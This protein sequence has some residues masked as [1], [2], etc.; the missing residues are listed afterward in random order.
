MKNKEME[1]GGDSETDL[2]RGKEQAKRETTQDSKWIFVACNKVCLFA[3]RF[4]C[5]WPLCTAMMGRWG[6]VKEPSLGES[7]WG[8]STSVFFTGGDRPKT[9]HIQPWL[10]T[11]SVWTCCDSI[12]FLSKLCSFVL[13][14]NNLSRMSKSGGTAL[15]RVHLLLLSISGDWLLTQSWHMFSAH[16]VNPLLS[17]HL[18]WPSSPYRTEAVISGLIQ[19]SAWA[20][21]K[22]F[23]PT[24]QVGM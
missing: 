23:L 8:L 11:A 18:S 9:K 2:D 3:C 21:L 20:T 17:S 13:L 4:M 5:Y 6:C 16:G 12:T 24:D 22:S 19:A 15:P 7:F 10:R 14:S 1:R